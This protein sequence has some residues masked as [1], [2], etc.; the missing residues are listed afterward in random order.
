MATTRKSP[1]SRAKKP[2][3]GKKS[4]GSTIQRLLS[5]AQIL[6][7]SKQDWT[8]AQ[9]QAKLAAADCEFKVDP[10]TVRRNLNMLERCGLIACIDGRPPKYRSLGK[11]TGTHMVKMY[12]GGRAK[13]SS[14]M[15]WI[16]IETFSSNM[17][18]TVEETLEVIQLGYLD[19][20]R[21]GG[22]WYVLELAIIDTPDPKQPTRGRLRIAGDCRKNCLIASTGVLTIDLTYDP[23][24][25]EE[26]ALTLLP[27]NPPQ[28]IA[29]PLGSR[30]Y[31]VDRSLQR[32]IAAAMIEWE[33]Q[34]L[35]VTSTPLNS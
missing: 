30:T 11:Q 26:T 32:S 10:N 2:K 8:V 1:A 22:Q 21:L 7:E 6:Q 33:V 29:V 34:F 16:P 14:P 3:E 13:D 19:G 15:R 24:T 35:D 4:S 9:M 5:M 31:L 12:P 28:H 20:I 23:E 27:D 25:H 18:E 17:G